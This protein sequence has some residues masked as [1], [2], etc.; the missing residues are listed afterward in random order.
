MNKQAVKNHL[1]EA[2]EQL[3]ISLAELGRKNYDEEALRVHISHVYHHLNSAWNGRKC[4][5]KQYRE[6]SD[7]NFSRWRKFPKISE[8]YLEPLIERREKSK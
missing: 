3:A 2:A 8:M 6:C 5:M 7:K 1:K 4:T